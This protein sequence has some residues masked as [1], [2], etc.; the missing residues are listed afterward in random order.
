MATACIDEMN[1]VVSFADKVKQFNLIFASC[2]LMHLIPIEVRPMFS[3]IK[4]AIETISLNI[5][6]GP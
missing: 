4:S 5:I 2:N 3:D 1:R 6:G